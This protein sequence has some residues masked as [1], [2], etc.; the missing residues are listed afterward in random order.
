MHCTYTG[1]IGKHGIREKGKP[2]R[3]YTVIKHGLSKIARQEIDRQENDRE[4]QVYM[5]RAAISCTV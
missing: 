1:S 5:K 2:R 3:V 4:C